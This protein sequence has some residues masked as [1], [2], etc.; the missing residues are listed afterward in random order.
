[1]GSPLSPALANLFMAE[2]EEKALSTFVNAPKTWFG[3]VDDMFSIIR[4]VDV[5]VF[6]AHLSQQHPSI[7]FML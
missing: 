4:K 3:F 6:L 5:E 2:L 1:M 7:Q